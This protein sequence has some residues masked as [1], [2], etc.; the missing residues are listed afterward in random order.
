MHNAHISVRSTAQSCRF[1]RANAEI[2]HNLFLLPVYVTLARETNQ[3]RKTLRP[4]KTPTKY[5][6]L[7]LVTCLPARTPDNAPAPVSA[8]PTCVPWTPASSAL[9]PCRDVPA[10]RTPAASASCN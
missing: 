10:P 2:P 8:Y 6:D 9:F 4:R 1:Q 7:F 5:P 3:G